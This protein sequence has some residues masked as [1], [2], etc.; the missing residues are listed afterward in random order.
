[1]EMRQAIMDNMARN[2]S[3]QPEK[4]LGVDFLAKSV[5][6]RDGGVDAQQAS[7]SRP[8]EQK[9]RQDHPTVADLKTAIA[10]SPIEF[11]PGPEQVRA[12]EAGD[13]PGRRASSHAEA[14]AQSATKLIL[15]PSSPMRCDVRDSNFGRLRSW[16]ASGIARRSRAIA[17][18]RSRGA[19][20][21]IRTACP[22]DL[23]RTSNVVR[24]SGGML[25][26][27]PG[28]TDAE[29]QQL[30]ASRAARERE[31]AEALQAATAKAQSRWA[32]GVRVKQHPYLTSK[33]ISG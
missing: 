22:R 20:K 30:A 13:A 11:P 4:Q 15:L 17:G 5:R 3:R 33:G 12:G 1:M 9:H 28:M 24:G 21:P 6:A 31:Q 8:A 29:R 23:S 26:D 16:M 25:I 19:T 32:A 14:R 10:H 18:T 27:R 7:W 2:L